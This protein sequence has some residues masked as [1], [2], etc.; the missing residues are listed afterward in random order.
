MTR[1][2]FFYFYFYSIKLLEAQRFGESI[3]EFQNMYRKN[4]SKFYDL[5]E[6]NA[7]KLILR[8]SIKEGLNIK[9]LISFA[10]L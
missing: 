2:K 5:T 3:L 10:C 1:V 6:S 7:N 8:K 9:C 4:T